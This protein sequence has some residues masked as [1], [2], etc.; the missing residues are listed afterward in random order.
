MASRGGPEMPKFWFCH[1]N[2]RFK[3][4]KNKNKKKFVEP[5]YHLWDDMN[6]TCLCCT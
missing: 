5:P 6:M 2:I 1:G 3:K 4:I